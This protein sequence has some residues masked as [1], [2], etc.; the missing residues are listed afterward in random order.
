MSKMESLA[1]DLLNIKEEIEDLK[2]EQASNEGR[3]HELVENLKTFGC[4][5]IEEANKMLQTIEKQIAATEIGF[6]HI[7]SELEELGWEI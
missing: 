1:S 6:A 5:N 2:K 3:L 7:I 4:K